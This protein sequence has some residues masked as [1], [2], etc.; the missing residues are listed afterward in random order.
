MI[1]MQ[2]GK[3]YVVC[4]LCGGRF[5]RINIGHLKKH[6]ITLAEYVIQFP[7]AQ[8]VS[9]VSKKLL[10]ESVK[11]SKLNTI[12]VSD[13]VKENQGKHFCHCGCGEE[14]E[15]KPHHHDPKVGIPKFISGHNML[16]SEA[17]EAAS[18]KVKKQFEDGSLKPFT[19]QERK[20]DFHSG[21]TKRQ[22][23]DSRKKWIAENPEYAAKSFKKAGESGV[24][25]EHT[26][27]WKQLASERPSP[28][29]GKHHSDESNEKN[30]QAHLKLISNDPEK[31]ERQQLAMQQAQHRRPT[32]PELELQRILEELLPDEYK[33]VGDWQFVLG[34][35]SPDF[36][37]VNGQKKLIEM[38]GDY[39]HSEDE[40][41]PRINHFKEYGFDTLIVWEHEL[42]DMDSLRGR[43]ID[44]NTGT[45]RQTNE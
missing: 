14:I 33:Y 7:D 10:S 30:R 31:W 5:R 1:N 8:I 37:N 24:G 36:M 42:Q 34:G 19:G 23:S 20:G 11:A 16:T 18:D 32:K 22:M 43:I 45:T 38:Y 15:I 9:G 35:K 12:T 21:G 25:W 44:F 4:Q 6:G 26:D 27:E 39:W 13:W 29:L 40:V 28:M 3:D 17:R 2:E 41:Q